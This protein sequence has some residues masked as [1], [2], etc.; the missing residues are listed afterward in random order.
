M[1]HL[2]PETAKQF[3]EWLDSPTSLYEVFIILDLDEQNTFDF[4][5]ISAGKPDDDCFEPDALEGNS[6]I[7]KSRCEK[8][9]DGAKPNKQE[10][11][12]WRKDYEENVLSGESG[13]CHFFGFKIKF[14]NKNY[15]FIG[16]LD[17]EGDLMHREGPFFTMG[18]VHAHLNEGIYTIE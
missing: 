1:N 5:G 14:K 16:Y 4:C 2:D 3:Q 6:A 13:W 8:L 7:S 17:S 12:L 18:E 15:Y 10:L 11:R 9:L